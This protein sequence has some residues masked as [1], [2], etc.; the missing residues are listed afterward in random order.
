MRRFVTILLL[1]ILAVTIVIPC[2]TEDTAEPSDTAESIRE[3][4]KQTVLWLADMYS[5]D[6][7]SFDADYIFLLHGYAQMCMAADEVHN[8]ELHVKAK[9]PGVVMN[10]STRKDS[11]ETIYS[12]YEMTE[13]YY[14]SWLAGKISDAEYC[15]KVMVLMRVIVA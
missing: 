15:Q 4:A 11:R 14:K 8:A 5:A 7:W 2:N 12:I 9:D 10:E 13:E 3:Y 1:V 6:P